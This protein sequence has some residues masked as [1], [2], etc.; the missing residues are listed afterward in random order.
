M[1][2]DIAVVS[3][4]LIRCPLGGYAW[5]NLHY[6][7]GLEELGFESWFYE[8]TALHSQCFDPRSRV[9]TG[10][11][12]PGL[13]TAAPFLAAHGFANRWILNDPWRGEVHGTSAERRDDV[14]TRAKVW[15]SLAAVNPVPP[16]RRGQSGTVFIDLDPGYTQIRAASGDPALLELLHQHRTHFTL[17]ENIGTPA[18]S[19]P[20]AGLEWRPT[21]SP[22][23]T[24]LWH[25][26][27]DAPAIW[28]TI[29]RWD[30]DRREV[31]L[32][33]VRYSWRKRSEWLKFLS[34][35][36]RTGERFRLAMD[37]EKVPGD[38]AL[39]REHG[40]DIVD[41][42]AVSHDAAE[43]RDFIRG[44]KGE[45]TVAKDLNVRLCT[46]WFSDRAACYLA[47]GRPVVNQRTGF[48][49]VLPIGHGLLDFTN[50][51]EAVEAIADVSTNPSE[52]GA[53][54]RRIAL[55]YFEAR[56]VLESLVS[57]V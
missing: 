53:A 57:A 18:C 50:L 17:G 4:Y 2:R 56:R 8:D 25:P 29:G 30:E 52:H 1:A 7:L 14:I 16:A 32:G 44:S 42:L 45:F 33:G 11:P 48:D 40:W 13:A 39:L 51:E 38:L 19:I 49:R 12:G 26:R 34:L 54:A 5:Q 6:L 15:V 20:T 41:P 43:Y 27:H 22:V 31:T 35:P 47:A 21:R 55:E 23:V 28:T 46:G 24:A 36:A 10:G 37:V 9:M 3:G